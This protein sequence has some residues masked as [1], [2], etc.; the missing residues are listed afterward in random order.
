MTIL[1]V[2]STDAETITEAITSFLNEKKLNHRKLVG[3]GYDS[4]AMF[5]GVNTGVQRRLRVHA[6]HALYTHCPC[7]HKLQL[8]S[9]KAAESVLV[10]KRMFGTMTSLWKMLHY[11][12]KQAETMVKPNDTWWLSH[13]R[14][15]RAILKE[16]PVLITTHQ[17]LHEE[18][19]DPEAYVLASVLSSY[20][21]VATIVLLSVVLDLLAKLNGFMQQKLLHKSI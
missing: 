4:A 13:E 6:P 20:S 7:R 14:C 1:H 17:E 21:G 2:K 15:I 10:I 8:A 12:P 18:S 9:I 11:S 3:Q 16:L 5:S 19:E